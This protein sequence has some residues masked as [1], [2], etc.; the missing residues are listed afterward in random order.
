[1]FRRA[2]IVLILITGILRAGPDDDFVEIYQLIQATDA[3]RENGRFEEARSGYTRAQEMLQ[4]LKKEYPDWN[5]RVVVYRL[6]YVSEKLS[7]LPAP[8]PDTAP[9]AVAAGKGPGVPAP[10]TSPPEGEVITQFRN[11]QSEISLL[12]SEKQK[13]EARLREALTAQPAPVD[14]KELQAAVERITQLQ[15]T[16]RMLAQRI[17]IQQAERRNLVD[18]V[19][20]DEAEEALKSAN[21]TLADQNEKTVSLEILHKRAEAELERLRTGDIAKLQ[22]ENSTLKSQVN[23]LASATD[24][25]DQIANLAERVSKL[26]AGLEEARQG[27]ETLL[28]ERAKLERDL[29][30]LRARQ[31]EESI[32]RLKQLETDLAFARA[33][34]QRQ[35]ARAVQL[36]EQL[37]REK[38]VRGTLEQSNLSLSNRVAELTAKVDGLKSAE[39]QLQAEK[40]ERA[41]LEAQLH[42]A[43][44]QLQVARTARPAADGTV[45]AAPADPLAEAK[46]QALEEEALRLRDALRQSRTRQ[47]ELLTLVAEADKSRVRWERERQELQATILALQKTPTQQQLAAANRSVT[48]LEER[49]RRLEK[50]RD[51]LARRLDEATRKSKTELQMVRR[52]RMGSPREEVVRFRMERN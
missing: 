38:G 44:Q 20:L 4:T 46:L 10:Q 51:T 17:E 27:N 29:E 2:L 32:V 13:L 1:M 15:A 8:T 43:E 49:V 26:Q 36:E 12:K 18:K 24:R 47:S 45:A 6:R 31:S 28:A 25:G 41:E 3:Q 52:M 37:G 11:F 23:E 22:T 48:S 9:V 40:E 30:N 35:T 19:L 50:E 42:A 34:G 21:R 39:L 5:E 7:Q 33:E 16:N 14:P